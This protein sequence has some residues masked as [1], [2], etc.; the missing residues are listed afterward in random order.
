M[1]SSS[2]VAQSFSTKSNLS[3][4]SSPPVQPTY[5]ICWSDILFCILQVFSSKNYQSSGTILLSRTYI[6]RSLWECFRKIKSS[7][8]QINYLFSLNSCFFFK[9]S[10]KKTV[11][12]GPCSCHSPASDDFLAKYTQNSYL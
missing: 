9:I 3:R 12:I 11:K 1:F 5:N 4:H 6:Q 10:E 7:R 2:T 8:N